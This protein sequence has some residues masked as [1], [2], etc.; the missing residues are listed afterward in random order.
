MNSGLRQKLTFFFVRFFDSKNDSPRQHY[1]IHPDFKVL[2]SV[3]V[4]KN[5]KQIRV[6]QLL[7]FQLMYS[8]PSRKDLSIRHVYIPS[9]SSP[10]KRV[11]ALV[12]ADHSLPEKETAPCLFFLHGG[13]F[14]FPALPYHYRF[15]R[16]VAKSLRCRVIM[17]MYHLCPG[18]L[19]PIQMEE[20]Y[21][22]YLQLRKDPE[23][24][25]IDPDRILAA[26]DSA[27]GTM[28]AAL[29]QM[30]RDRGT[31]MPIAQ[32]LFYPSLD[33]RL[34]SDSMKAFPDVPICN[35]DAIRSYYEICAPQQEYEPDYYS[36]MEAASVEGLPPA[37]IE[38]AE[39]D[40]LHDDGIGYAKRLRDA[41]ISVVLNETKGTCHAYEMVQHSSITKQ[42][43]EERLR[44]IR[45]KLKAGN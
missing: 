32:A 11:R 35:A 6:I 19:P 31:P 4:A 30:T 15:A 39:F 41:G 36:P 5:I 14:L 26:G 12:F 43:M 37:Y 7:Y 45:E 1:A 40:A 17:P 13:A 34:S 21:E 22:V 2:W 9:P 29:C 3:P 42:A 27:G 23:R 24:F 38:T 28:A 16:L 8:E 25:H 20:M 33:S 44:F 10:D 18:K